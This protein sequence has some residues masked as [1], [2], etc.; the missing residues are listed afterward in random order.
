MSETKRL[1]DVRTAMFLDPQ[2]VV[3]ASQLTFDEKLV[4]LRRWKAGLERRNRKRAPM[5]GT[6][7]DSDSRLAAVLDAMRRLNRS[8]S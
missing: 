1:F 4:V 6:R 5:F 7:P 2:D 3:D 8:G